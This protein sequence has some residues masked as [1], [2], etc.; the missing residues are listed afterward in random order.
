M[1]ALPT[2]IGILLVV[3]AYFLPGL[4]LVR[5][6]EWTRAEP[7]ELAAVACVGSAAWWAIGLWFVGWLRF[8]LSAFAVGSLAV[9][10][11]VLAFPR[12]AAIVA[13]FAGWRACPAPALWGLTFVIAVLGTRAIF[14]FTRLA[15]SVGDMSAHAYMAELIVM[16]DDLPSTYEPFLPI[17]AFGSFPPGFHALAAIETLLGGVPIYRST[18]H[19]L[20]FSFVALTFTLAALLR[21]VGVGRTGSALGAAGALVLARNPQFFEQW[22]GG[23]MLLATALVFLVLRDGLRLAEPCPPGFLARLGFLSAATLLTHPLPV[24]SFLYV[25]PVAAALRIGCN[26]AA[27]FRLA[28]NGAVVLA[29][30]G[31][32]AVPFFGR[33]PR[34]IPPDVAAFARDW[35]RTEAKNALV[36]Q[37]QALR[38]LGAAGLSE[39][40]G[41]HTWPFYIICYLG[42]LPAVL[43]A[44]G[45][46]VRWLRERNSVTVLATALV[47]VHLILFTG[48]LT[49]MLPLW[50]SFYPTR[51]GIWLA[52]AL[53]I[54]F[55][56]LGSLAATHVR[57]RTLCAA[58]MLWLGLFALEGHRL[59]AYRFGIAY[60]EPAKAGHGSAAVILANE[61]VGG[62]FWVATFC[63]DNAVLTLDDLRA[64][65]WIAEHT[66]PAA[67]FATNYGDGGNMIASVAHRAVIN[68]HFENAMFYQRELDEWRRRT[69]VD[70][71]YVSSEAGPNNTRTYTA[72]ALE[73]D[74][75]VE[76]AFQA[77]EARVY[78]VK[79]R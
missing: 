37:E 20:C 5:R 13:A 1:T 77:G 32:L 79:R 75:S 14:A 7:V 19:A 3:L 61:A 23:P 78:K 67:V 71:I 40:I 74:P 41:P 2:A 10:A 11:L 8:P 50:A 65:T 26:R 56:G 24:T 73:R 70:Y 6:E 47:S 29:V 45:L 38:A 52:P 63:R 62:A 31:A 57:R 68:P 34:S 36:P 49:E 76:L 12:R 39:R 43:L 42:L 21:G 60:Y 25:F 17:G 64:F 46:A 35:L 15:C 16:R 48:G 44:L 4:A 18:I 51:I 72:E 69:P 53:A 22:G 9:A 30:A 58:G 28:R 54:A 27:W 66:P 55:A 33:V 59:S